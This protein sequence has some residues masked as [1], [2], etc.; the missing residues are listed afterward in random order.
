MASIRRGRR[1]ARAAGLGRAVRRD[2]RSLLHA[3]DHHRLRPA[4]RL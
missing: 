1:G 2:R 3:P 4:G